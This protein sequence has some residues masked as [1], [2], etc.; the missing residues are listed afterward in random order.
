MYLIFLIYTSVS[1]H[2]DY[3]YVLPI[4]NSAA[5]NIDVHVFLLF[6][7]IPAVYGGSQARGPIRALA[8]SLYHSHSNARSEPCLPSTPQL[9][10]TPDP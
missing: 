3:F 4:V 5:V 10:A 8:A 9:T 1:G 2:L 6:R 7:A